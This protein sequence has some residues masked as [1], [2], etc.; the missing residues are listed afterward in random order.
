MVPRSMFLGQTVPGPPARPGRG[1]GGLRPIG[2]LGSRSPEN[3]VHSL[4]SGTPL[5][6]EMIGASVD[7]FPRPR[8]APSRRSGRKERRADDGTDRRHACNQAQAPSKTSK[9]ADAKPKESHR[10]T[11]EAIVVALILALVVRGFEAQAFVIP[12]GSMAP[13]LMGRHKELSC[14]QCGF[15]Y[16]VNASEEVEGRSVPPPG[17]LGNLRQLPLPGARAVEGSQLQG[18]PDPG[19]DVSLRPAVPAGLLAAGAV[20][21]RGLPLSRGA[22][23]QLHQAAGRAARRDDPDPS[24]RYLHQAARQ[25]R[26]PARAEAALAPVGHADDRLRRSA[27]AQ[28]RWPT[29]PNGSAGNPRH[30]AGRSPIP[31]SAAIGPRQHPAISGSSSATGTWCPTPS[32]GMPSSMTAR[33]LET[34]GRR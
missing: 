8:P 27:S 15:V 3:P 6:V 20:G 12:T 25:R 30:P 18:G 23:G 10:D 17:L 32:N 21:R 33:C 34:R 22:R 4:A 7:E 11:V 1:A 19:D 9:E 29:S 14:P 5:A 24:W 16:T 31:L 26:L 28:R 13:T 2:L